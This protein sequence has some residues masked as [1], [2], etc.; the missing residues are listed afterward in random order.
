MTNSNK[1]YTGKAY[2]FF[3]CN[4]P[5]KTIEDYLS[6]RLPETDRECSHDHPKPHELGLELT[7]EEVPELRSDRDSDG[8]LIRFVDEMQIYA[9][10]PSSHKDEMKNAKPKTLRNVKYVIKAKSSGPTNIETAEKLTTVMN[11]VYLRFG[12]KKP[13][14]V[15]VTWKD[16]SGDYAFWDNDTLSEMIKGKS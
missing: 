11:D 14:Y 9:T 12:E 5:R 2:A 13:F 8:E 4:A 3:D 15:A 1:N 10:Y 6:G 7:L 16:K